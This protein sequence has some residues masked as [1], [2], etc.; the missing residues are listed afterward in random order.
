M[1]IKEEI[2]IVLTI[3]E[4]CKILKDHFSEK[5][6]IEHAYFDIKTV[7]DTPMDCYGSQEVKEVRLV[8]KNKEKQ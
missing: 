5:Y 8:G 4:A 3:A 2:T 1:K 6:D 7:Y